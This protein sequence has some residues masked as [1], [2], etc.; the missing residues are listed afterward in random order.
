MSEL[1]NRGNDELHG[2]DLLFG[3]GQLILV[4]SKSIGDKI[5]RELLEVL[6]VSDLINDLSGLQV[7]SEA[8]FG[9]RILDGSEKLINLEEHF[10]ELISAM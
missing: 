1:S 2:V 5:I 7:E 6:V 10:L 4:N 9:V 8:H 3:V